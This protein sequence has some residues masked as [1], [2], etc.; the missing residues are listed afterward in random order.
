[1]A[2]DM[3]ETW[4]RSFRDQIAQ[5]AYNSAPVEALVRTVSHHLRAR[6]ATEQ[7]RDLHFLEVGCGAGPNLVWLARRGILA[8]GVDISPTALD[9]AR[10]NLAA[11]APA[12]RV[13]RLEHASASALPF[14]D[15][16]LDGVLEACVFQHL[17]KADRIAA[18][19]EVG[20]VLKPGGVFVGY[21]IGVGHSTFQAKR[22]AEL[23]DDPGTVTLD[24][25]ADG[26]KVHLESIGLA[27][28]FRREEF[29]GLLPG[30]SVVDPCETTY[31]LPREEAARRGVE[32]YLQSMW[33]V[34]AV[35]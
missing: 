1:M 23:P 4:E 8:S 15:S 7:Y 19:A 31:E 30:F 35:K 16:S 34:Y 17:P 21:M 9:L 13:G 28:F 6:Y 11:S 3:Q 18:F 5:A 27:H 20:R 10:R 25:S 29:A 26:S 24:D 12:D 2:D 22:A 14:A 33:V 32:R